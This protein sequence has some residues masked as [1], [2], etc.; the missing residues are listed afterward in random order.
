MLAG[1]FFPGLTFDNHNWAIQ[2]DGLAGLSDGWLALWAGRLPS[3][4][5]LSSTWS[6]QQN[7]SG[8][9]PVVTAIQGAGFSAQAL[10]KLNRFH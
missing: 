10:R 8:F 5:S 7:S 9:L 1:Q 6:L 3:P 4:G 2:D